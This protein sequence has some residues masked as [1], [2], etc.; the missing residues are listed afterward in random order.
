[1][2]GARRLAFLVLSFLV[3]R[4]VSRRCSPFF[5]GREEWMPRRSF[6]ENTPAS[7]AFGCFENS[8]ILLAPLALVYNIFPEFHVKRVNSFSTFTDNF[9][10]IANS[11]LHIDLDLVERHR[12][13]VVTG[14]VGKEVAEANDNPI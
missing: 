8:Q 10:N 9:L 6:R 1:M 2:R 12:L 4:F 5:P 14:K 13:V 3:R 11:M 7:F